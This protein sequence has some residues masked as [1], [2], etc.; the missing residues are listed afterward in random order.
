M[1]LD[2]R[3]PQDI[4]WLPALNPVKIGF[5]ITRSSE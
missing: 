2:M 1:R 4:L 5:L 3:R